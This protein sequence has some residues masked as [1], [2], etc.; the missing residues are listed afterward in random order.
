[1]S[2]TMEAVTLLRTFHLNEK[3]NV[4]LLLLWHKEHCWHVLKECE[5]SH[6]ILIS[7]QSLFCACLC[8]SLSLLHVLHVFVF[9][10]V[11]PFFTTRTIYVHTFGLHLVSPSIIYLKNKKPG[12][13][14]VLSK[15][16]SNN[17]TIYSQKPAHIHQP[18]WPF[19]VEPQL[20]WQALFG[21]CSR[22]LTRW[23]QLEVCPD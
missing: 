3:Q 1:M 2:W 23:W 21:I 16:G 9:L 18:L 10:C 11:K 5:Y 6:E 19:A 17:Y 22:A 20:N 15:E 7:L 4:G 12:R 8:T 14:R 13:D